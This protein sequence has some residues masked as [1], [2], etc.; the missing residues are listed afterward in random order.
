MENNKITPLARFWLLLKPDKKEIKNVYI[1][2]FFNGLVSLSLPLGIQAIINL[3]QGGSI[4]TSW[5]V[6]VTFVIMGITISG[7]LQIQQLKITEYLQQR[8]FTRAAFEF[9]YRI[10]RIKLEALYNH[11]APELMNRFFD[12]TSVQKGLSKILLDFSA[13]SIQILF[14]LILLSLYH[15][16]FIIYSLILII[17]VYTIFKLTSAKGLSTSLYESKYKYKVVHWLE[18][19]ARTSVSFKLAGNSELPMQKV[20]EYTGDYINSRDSHFR[21]LKNQYTLMVIFKVLVSAGLL[22]VGSLLVMDQQM[23][24]GQ[25][26]AAEIIILLVL[27]AVEKLILSLES[28]YDILTSL[29]KIGQVTDLELEK[30]SGYDF[31]VKNGG[32]AIEMLDLSFKYPEQTNYILKNVSIVITPGERVLLKGDRNSGKATLLNL[33]AGL[34][35]IKEGN[36]ILDTLPI[37]NYNPNKLRGSIGDCLMNE[38]LFEGSVMEN[39]TMGREKASYENV[40]WAVDN[41]ELG[42]FVKRLPLGLDTIYNPQGKQF[43]KGIVDKIILARSVADKPKLLLIKDVF[44]SFYQEEKNR[45][46]KFLTSDNNDWTLITASND[47]NLLDMMNTVYSVQNKVITKI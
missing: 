8:I 35:T 40:L 12:V 37:G 36:L 21:V 28:I 2:A 24:I 27:G 23:N 17:L 31:E 26:V 41:L 44:S 7:V 25:F 15:P 5:F 14:G 18:E 39:I 3:I 9:A 47:K 19:L 46:F 4:S 22:I 34:Y 29:E 32:M 43:S 6:L 33:F 11:Y 42:E 13:A 16:F 1:Y 20:D 45:I 10:P 38:L 30:N